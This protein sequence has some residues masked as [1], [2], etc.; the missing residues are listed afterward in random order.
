MKKSQPESDVASLARTGHWS[1][2]SGQLTAKGEEEL[3]RLFGA[4]L[5]ESYKQIIAEP[6][7]SHLQ[8]LLTS[9]EAETEPR[10]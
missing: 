3:M 7:P 6:M 9:L 5:Q 1:I 8:R 4:N 10:E 2:S